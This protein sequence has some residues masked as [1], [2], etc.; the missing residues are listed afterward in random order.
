[1][2]EGQIKAIAFPTYEA[3]DKETELLH[4]L[5]RGQTH[6]VTD[7]EILELS[8]AEAVDGLLAS[9]AFGEEG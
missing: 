9:K 7:K 1:M 4:T 8:S 2:S 6:V 3:M 5:I